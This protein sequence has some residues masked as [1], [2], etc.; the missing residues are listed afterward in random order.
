ML[1]EVTY[2]RRKRTQG[3]IN[4]QKQVRHTILLPEKYVY[5]SMYNVNRSQNALGYAI[6]AKISSDAQ[7]CFLRRMYIDQGTMYA[8]PKIH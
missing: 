7:S 2:R 8:R 4:R 6:I 5:R 3:C 1:I